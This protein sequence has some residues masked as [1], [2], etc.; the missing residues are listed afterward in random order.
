M[1]APAGKATGPS[2]STMRSLL[3]ATARA[4]ASIACAVSRATHTCQKIYMVLHCKLVK[5][6]KQILHIFNK[7][8]IDIVRQLRLKISSQ[9]L[10]DYDL[11][12][13]RKNQSRLKI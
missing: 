2:C 8:L 6:E 1:R 5:I 3:C 10:D 4:L 7:F 12:R 9:F 11:L 13:F